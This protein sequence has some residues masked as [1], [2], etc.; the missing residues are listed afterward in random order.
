MADY[1]FEDGQGH[2]YVFSRAL[3]EKTVGVADLSA[4][5][6]DGSRLRPQAQDACLIGSFRNQSVPK[7]CFVAHIKADRSILR[8]FAAEA[9]LNETHHLFPSS[10]EDPILGALLGLPWKEFSRVPDKPDG[11]PIFRRTLDLPEYEDSFVKI[12]SPRTA[13]YRGARVADGIDLAGAKDGGIV[14]QVPDIAIFGTADAW[15]PLHFPKVRELLAQHRCVAFEVDQLIQHANLGNNAYYQKG[16]VAW[17]HEPGLVELCEMMVE[18]PGLDLTRATL[19]P[20]WYYRVDAEGVWKRE[21][22]AADCDCGRASI[23][24]RHISA[25]QITERFLQAPEEFEGL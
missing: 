11:I 2:L 24:Q 10:K 15:M 17:E 8:A 14:V 19:V 1:E 21:L 12:A 22:N 13:F 6:V 7:E 3:A 4:L 25:L 20:G 16:V 23:H 9:G 18:H 5:K